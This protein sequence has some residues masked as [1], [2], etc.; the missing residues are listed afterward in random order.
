VNRSVVTTPRAIPLNQALLDHLDRAGADLAGS[1]YA[2]PS[3]HRAAAA[4]LLA[5]RGLWIHAD[6]FADAATGVSL[7][8]ITQLADEGTGLIDV[9]LLTTDALAALDV[10]CRPGVARITFPYEGTV[11]VEAVAARVRAVG[12][13]PWLAISPATGIS[14]CYAVLRH[15]DGLLVMLIEPGTQAAADTSHLGKVNTVHRRYPTG[16]DGGVDEAN[17]A[18]VLAAGT[19]YVVVGRRLFTWAHDSM[20]KAKP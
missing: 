17:A 4:H 5:D 3:G 6:V 1:L 10:V 9:H 12:V 15:V 8:L 19:R 11:D 18:D 14:E 2:C 16:V 13:K 7:E 20:A